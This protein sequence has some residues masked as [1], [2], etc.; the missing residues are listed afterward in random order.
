M[1]DFSP[2]INVDID[3]ATKIVKA[4]VV[5]HNFVCE[6]DGYE[7]ELDLKIYIQHIKYEANN[8]RTIS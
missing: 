6:K 4:C 1:E 3:F 7:V 8:V 5:L 2:A